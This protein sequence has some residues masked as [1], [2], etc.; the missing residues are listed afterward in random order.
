MTVEDKIN[1][2]IDKY[3]PK[4]EFIVRVANR[5]ALDITFYFMKKFADESKKKRGI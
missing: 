3:F 1:E 5:C 2:I 4:I